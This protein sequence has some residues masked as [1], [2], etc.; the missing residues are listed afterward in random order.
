VHRLETRLALISDDELLSEG[1]Q[2]QPVPN[3]LVGMVRAHRVAYVDLLGK[4]TV[5]DA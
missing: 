2:M 5:E 1:S 3:P 4:L